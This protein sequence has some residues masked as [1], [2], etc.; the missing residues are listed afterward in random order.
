M[1]LVEEYQFYWIKIDEIVVQAFKVKD[2]GKQGKKEV[3]CF[4]SFFSETL[5]S[6]KV[7]YFPSHFSLHSSFFQ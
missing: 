5:S 3:R 6:L 1:D 7:A 4:A 2:I